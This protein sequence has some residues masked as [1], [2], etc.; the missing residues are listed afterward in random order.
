M[1]DL[2]I[3]NGKVVDGS[4]LPAFNADL[5]VK[6]GVIVKIGPITEEAIETIDAEGQV[7][8]PGFIDPHTHFDAQ[9]LWDGAAKPA[10]EHGVTTIVPGNCSLSLA[11][12]KAEHRMKLVGMFNQIEEMPYKA[13]AEGVEW[14][15]ETFEE[16][17]RRIGRGLNIN[18]APLVGHS[19]LRL[20]VMGDDS[21]KRIA[22]LSETQSMCDLLSECLESGAIGLSTS[23]ID[24]DERLQPVPSR[25]ADPQELDALC[26]V[27]AQH[28]KIL[29]VVH[30]FYDT[31]LSLARV[32]QLADISLIHGINT[33][34]SPL[35]VDRNNAAGAQKIVERVAEQTER[36]ARVW[37]QVQ[38]RPIDISFNFSVP[39]LLFVRLPQ[40]YALMRFN[41][42]EQIMASLKDQNTRETL[43]AEA[44]GMMP[45]WNNLVLRQVVSEANQGMVGKTL[46]EIAALRQSDALNVMIDLSLEESLEAHFLSAD[47]GHNDDS[48]VAPLLKHPNVMIGASDGGAHILSFATYG[49]TGYLLGHFVRDTAHL[50]LEAA[51]KKITADP[52]NLWG[53]GNRGML[54][55]GFIADIT[56]FDASVVDRGAEYFV[57]DVPGDGY[58]YVRD[59]HGIH[60]VVIGGALAYD[61]A[62]GYYEAHRGQVIG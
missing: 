24:M 40:W 36:G 54:R 2:I 39:S 26:A 47:M 62:N 46:K 4:G 35:F 30:E 37:P 32:D 57:Q 9:L 17:V 31:D 23:F 50:G 21:M 56:V 15:W 13:F 11:P 7:V 59:A 33:T 27:L 19:V 42:P 44:Q 49:D 51:V 38:T 52:A 12:L 18:V 34:L 22:S 25:Y 1:L 60:S 41:G 55:E 5:G 28:N 58:R 16:F 14:N 53:M 29:Q 48:L 61:K 6:D 3:R 8:A 10:I 43:I 20:W 45:L